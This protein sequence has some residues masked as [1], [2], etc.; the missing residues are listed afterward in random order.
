[1]SNQRPRYSFDSDGVCGPCR[2]TEMKKKTRLI[3]RK[4]KELEILLEK[5]RKNNGEYDIVVPCSGGKDAS[6]IA[7]KLKH[8]GGMTP[9]CV[10]FHLHY[11]AI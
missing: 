3:M 4:K 10:A 8:G 1:M 9:L 6:T 5:Y 2:Y 7:H 11:I